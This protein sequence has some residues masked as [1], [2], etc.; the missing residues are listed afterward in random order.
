[1]T[2]EAALV[3][4]LFLFFFLNL[5]SAMEM[6]RLH[7][8][9]E[10]ALWEI[11]NR[12]SV[13]GYALRNPEGITREQ[14]DGAWVEDLAG[15]VLSY[16]YIRNEVLDYL[17]QD[18]LENSPMTYGA[19]GLQFLESELFGEGDTFEVIVTYAISPWIDVPGFRSFRMANRYYGHLWTGY[20]IPVKETDVEQLTVYVT[21]Y[22]TVYHENRECSHIR[23]SVQETTLGNALSGTNSRGEKYALCEKCKD[24][25]LGETVYITSQGDC[26]HYTKECPGIRRIVY[27][28]LKSQTEKYAPCSRCVSP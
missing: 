19:N 12:V 13:Y 15:I 8:N 7:G 18:Y 23:L 14:K 21:E 24:F 9:L 27:S 3:L 17:G 16:S 1:M 10:L 20:E 26:Y 25:T 22:G 5:G 2:V 4:P 6:I 11:G 28:M